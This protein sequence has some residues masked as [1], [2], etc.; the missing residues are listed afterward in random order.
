MKVNETVHHSTCGNCGKLEDIVPSHPRDGY[1][2]CMA[3]TE[4]S[5]QE[6][7]RMEMIQDCT[8]L[9]RELGGEVY[10]GLALGTV[11]IDNPMLREAARL[12]IKA[13][14]KAS[15]RDIETGERLDRDKPK[16]KV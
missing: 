11:L 6:A 10:Y 9:A 16:V 12:I 13:T 4:W 3:E 2:D 14:R 8:K 7:K 15:S 1:C 5:R